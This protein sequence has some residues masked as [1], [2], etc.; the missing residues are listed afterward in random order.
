MG[1]DVK[2]DIRLQKHDAYDH[3]EDYLSMVPHFVSSGW[4]FLISVHVILAYMLSMGMPPSTMISWW[5]CIV[6]DD[7]ID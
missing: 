4:G 7:D 2:N 5:K 1:C 6:T 3:T